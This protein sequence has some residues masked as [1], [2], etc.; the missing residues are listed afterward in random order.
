MAPDLAQIGMT[1]MFIG[2]IAVFAWARPALHLTQEVLST[3]SSASSL[4]DKKGTRA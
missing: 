2:S 4:F 1:L 3:L